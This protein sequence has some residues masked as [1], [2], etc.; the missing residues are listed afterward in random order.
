MKI[1][2]IEVKTGMDRTNIRFYEREGLISPVRLDNGYREFSDED[3]E[4]LL[5]I[6]L[7]RSIHVPLD[8]IRGLMEGEISL[9]N[10][11]EEQIS[12]LEGEKEDVN[13]AQEICR[14]MKKEEVSL[15]GLHAKK[16]LDQL[17]EKAVESKTDYFSVKKDILP[18][19]YSPWRRFL[20]RTVDIGIYSLVF[21]AVLILLF[22]MITSRRSFFETVLVTIAVTILMLLIEPLL[23][24]KFATT[25]G[26]AIFGLEVKS[27][28]GNQ[29]SYEEGFRRTLGVI[30]YGLGFQIPI[31]NL[32]RGYKSYK[33]LEEEEILP[34]DEEV[35]YTMKDEKPYRTVLFLGSMA[36]FVGLSV[37]LLQVEALPPNRGELTIEEFVQNYK[38]YEK[39]IGAE[40]DEYELNRFGEWISTRNDRGTYVDL[41]YF[42]KPTFRFELSDQKIQS[43]SFALSI[44]NKKVPIASNNVEMLLTYLS[45]IGAQKKMDLFS[46]P[47]DETIFTVISSGFEGFKSSQYGVDVEA[48]IT[49]EGYEV[50]GGMLFPDDDVAQHSYLL[51]FSADVP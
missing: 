40:S 35:A 13:Y 7:L 23:L 36:I 51:S 26:K 37:L 32:V 30:R 12:V 47:I 29:L 46:Q 14:V 2:E 31:Y 25:P 21:D 20:A 33:A 34:W 4:M 44:Y 22:Q 48:E 18:Q 28:E 41:S 16:Y 50:M 42:E 9:P 10:L 5:R 19:V 27:P 8:Q 39:L 11:L 3:L 17:D 45:L 49:Y 15:R 6:K 43:I 1:R 38:H 24:M